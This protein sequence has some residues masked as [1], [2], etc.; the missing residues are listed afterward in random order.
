VTVRRTVAGWALAAWPSLGCHVVVRSETTRPLATERI[1]HLEGAVARRPTVIWTPA[2]QLRF[3]EPLE[4]PSEERV[5]QTTAIETAIRPNLATFTVGL[6]A[7]ALGGVMLTSGLFSAQSSNLYTYG[8]LAGVGVGLPLAIGPWLG[9]RTEVHNLPPAEPAV[10]VRRPGPVQPC[11]ERPLAASAAT[12][13]VGGVE[14]HGAIDRD[15]V[16]APSPYQW[17]DAYAAAS[18]P[19]VALTATVEQG[20]GRRTV[21]AVLDAEAIASHAAAYLAHADFDAHVEPF[22]RV[23]GLVAGPVRASLVTGDAGAA[24]RVVLPLRNDGPGDAWG[25][26]GQIAAPATPAI[27]GRILYIGA[28]RRGASSARELVIP[29]AAPAAS[30]LRGQTIELSIELHDAH[31]TAPSTPVRF[32]GSLGAPGTP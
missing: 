13:A 27:D 18:A 9:N 19:A 16:F 2:G 14:V 29:V 12:L 3:V 5:R 8:G 6:I 7:S 25:V 11:G 31:G 23:T 21:D 30:A 22:Q 24:V 20:A 28:L 32:R 15:G 10:V 17:I 4:C 1:A 26:R